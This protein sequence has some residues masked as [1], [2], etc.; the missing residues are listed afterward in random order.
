MNTSEAK[1]VNK[2]F[3]TEINI[4]YDQEYDKMQLDTALDYLKFEE[5]HNRNRRIVGCAIKWGGWVTALIIY[6]YYQ[7]F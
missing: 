1:T 4:N 2:N 3:K 7:L 5:K 6:I